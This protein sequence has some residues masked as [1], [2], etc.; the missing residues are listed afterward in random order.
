MDLVISTLNVISIILINVNYFFGEIFTSLEI[1][2]DKSI[3]TFIF[4]FQCISV[5]VVIAFTAAAPQYRP[6][7]P[8]T[9]VVPRTSVAPLTPLTV[10]PPIAPIASIGSLNPLSPIAP[11][12]ST[13]VTSPLKVAGVRDNPS[14]AIILR[15]ENVNNGIDGYSYA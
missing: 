14:S 1:C 11:I 6:I 9:S 4:F 13:G 2:L 12:L 15:Y 8:I 3:K 5:L 10:R 7:S